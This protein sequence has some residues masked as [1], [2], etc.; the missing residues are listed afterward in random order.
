MKHLLIC[1]KTQSILL[2]FAFLKNNAYPFGATFASN[3]YHGNK[4]NNLLKEPYRNIHN[5]LSAI[6]LLSANMVAS[7]TTGA[8]HNVTKTHSILHEMSA[9]NEVNPNH[10]HNSL[11]ESE[12]RDPQLSKN[13]QEHKNFMAKYNNGSPNAHENQRS[14]EYNASLL[15]K[16]LYSYVTPLL[17][18]AQQRPLDVNDSFITPAEKQMGIMVP[19]LESKYYGEKSA[20]LSAI[21]KVSGNYTKMSRLKLFKNSLKKREKN[22]EDK[23]EDHYT[24]SESIILG[25]VH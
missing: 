17:L 23:N 16:F 25:K 19:L 6:T 15:S 22:L 4:H 2:V 14:G 24:I 3:N 11:L 21:R 12:L 10:T 7:A 8:T 1:T 13:G 18:T 20:A 9:W 5:G